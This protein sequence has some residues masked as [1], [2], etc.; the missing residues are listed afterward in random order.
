MRSIY[1]TDKYGDKAKE[2]KEDAEAL[3]TSVGV[4]QNQYVKTD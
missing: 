4:I 3:G 2:M 1:L